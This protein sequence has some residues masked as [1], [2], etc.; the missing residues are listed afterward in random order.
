MISSSDLR[1]PRLSSPPTDIAHRPDW[2][3]LLAASHGGEEE[4]IDR[5]REKS[6]I[7]VHRLG[8][9]LFTRELIEKRR[10]ILNVLQADPEFD[11]SQNHYLGPVE[12]LSVAIARGK[13]L[14]Q[15][16]VEQ[17]WS[18][19]DYQIAADLISEP[20]PYGLHASL[21]L[22]TL[23]EQG[24]TQQHEKFLEKA[25]NW[26]YIGCYAQTELGHGSNVRGL[27]TT[28]T[29]NGEEKTFVIHTPTL[30]ASKWWIGSLGKAA[31]HAIVM[32]QLVL[33]GNFLL[34]HLFLHD[35]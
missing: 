23:R 14:R 15:H 30:T 10:Q 6:E 5:E 22:V 31:N 24:A 3:Q 27:E 18:D 25:E 34:F 9:F 1:K 13:R 17:D 35:L 4:V 20:D 12:K 19:D 21:F 11:K 29:W 8:N 32:A 7:D 28:A 2:V 26:E 33:V 16:S